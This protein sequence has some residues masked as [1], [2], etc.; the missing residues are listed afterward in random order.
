MKQ[1][2]EDL[3]KYLLMNRKKNIPVILNYYI[4]KL[5]INRWFN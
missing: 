2:A 1:T 5:Q 4:I 3:Q